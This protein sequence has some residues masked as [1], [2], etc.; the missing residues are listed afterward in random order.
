[1]FDFA[2]DWGYVRNNPAKKVKF[3]TIPRQEN[4]SMTPEEVRLFLDHVQERWYAL[5]LTAIVGGL[6][7]GELL[8]M[9][10]SKVDWNRGQYFVKETLRR[11]T[12]DR[13]KEFGPPK[14]NESAQ[15]VDL[16]PSCLDALRTHQRRQAQEKLKAGED[17]HDHDLIFAQA[18]GKPLDHKNV[19]NRVFTPGL[20]A[21]G[22]RTTLRFHDLRHTCASL[23]IAQ[24]E[25]LKYVQ[26]QLRH[27]SID[28]TFDTY[29][30]LFPDDNREAARRLDETL[31][32]KKGRATGSV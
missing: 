14:T 5:F 2:V 17:Y 7:I 15:T 20:K 32:G 4:D 25:S 3:P 27:A 6:R 9:R 23:L 29:G 10:W 1:M 8:A 21:A 30:H 12:K 16:T 19:V 31:F 11:K 13:P 22:I 18:N 26:K 24:G 28:I